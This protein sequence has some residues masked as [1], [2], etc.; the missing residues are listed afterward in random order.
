MTPD[1]VLAASPAEWAFVVA[2]RHEHGLRILAET[3]TA[4][5]QRLHEEAAALTGDQAMLLAATRN[6]CDELSATLATVTA[7]R[8]LLRV[9][10][11]DTLDQLADATGRPS[12]FMRSGIATACAI[13]IAAQTELE[14]DDVDWILT[15]NPPAHIHPAIVEKVS[16][17]RAA[18]LN[19]DAAA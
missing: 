3:E 11:A 8:D 10:I 9:D 12:F 17:L 15:G 18:Q 2:L 6:R 19:Q 16:K 4:G 7:E 1:I 13:D 14:I 5:W